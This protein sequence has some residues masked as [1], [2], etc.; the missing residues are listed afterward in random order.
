MKFGGAGRGDGQ[1]SH[2]TGIAVDSNG[3]IFVAD[4]ENKNVQKFDSIGNFIVTWDMGGDVEFK[5]TPEAIAVDANGHVYVTDYVLGRL[6]VFDNDG[7]FLWARDEKGGISSPSKR[8]VGIAFDANGRIFIAN[9]SGN[10]VEVF[11]LP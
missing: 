6:Q 7:R 4:Y 2:A 10:N 9:Q 11:Y 3:N 8:P 1:F 5:G